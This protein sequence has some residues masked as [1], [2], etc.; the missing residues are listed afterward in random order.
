MAFCSNARPEINSLL[1]VLFTAAVLHIQNWIQCL[2]FHVLL[3][4][5][6]PELNWIQCL[7]FHVMLQSCTS[8]IKFSVYRFM[9]CFNLAYQ[10][11]NSMSTV[12]FTAAVLHI[13]NWIQCL[14]FHVLLQYCTSRTELNVYP[15]IYCCSIAHPHPHFY[16]QLQFN[17]SLLLWDIHI[18]ARYRWECRWS[19]DYRR[20]RSSAGLHPL[21]AFVIHLCVQNCLVYSHSVFPRANEH[22][23]TPKNSTVRNICPLF[24]CIVTYFREQ[25]LVT[26]FCFCTGLAFWDGLSR[27]SALTPRTAW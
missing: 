7:A 18:V 4:S 5:C 12:S 11:L 6:N 27:A 23:R 16:E 1:T 3:Q 26:T 8:R 13:Q 20:K 21:T 25:L 17:F 22:F 9:Y 10:E 24:L 2:P 15:F 19:L 14:P